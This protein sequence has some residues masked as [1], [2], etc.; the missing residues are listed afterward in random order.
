MTAVAYVENAAYPA[1][2]LSNLTNAGFVRTGMDVL[3]VNRSKEVSR[4]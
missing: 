2:W 3:V 4:G 1:R